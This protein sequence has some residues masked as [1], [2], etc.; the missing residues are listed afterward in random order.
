MDFAI[1]YLG[2][3]F[4]AKLL[5][6]IFFSSLFFSLIIACLG[7]DFGF[8]ESFLKQLWV[9]FILIPFMTTGFIGG[10]DLSWKIYLDS[11][12]NPNEPELVFAITAFLVLIIYVGIAGKA[13]MYLFEIIP[14]KKRSDALRDT[15]E[16]QK[17]DPKV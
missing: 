17:I 12:G 7:E 16:S 8:L 15:E 11:A 3:T 1:E 10:V 2:F 13:S 4:D 5:V 9:F 6:I 14:S